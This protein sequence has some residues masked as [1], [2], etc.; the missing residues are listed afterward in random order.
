MNFET[1]EPKYSIKSKST[2]RLCI[3]LLTTLL[4][5]AC[6]GDPSKTYS[7]T[8][9]YVRIKLD[10]TEIE[11]STTFE[12][13]TV[14]VYRV[15]TGE[16]MEEELILLQ[17]SP[18]QNGKVELRGNLESP[19]WVEAQVS[20][21]ESSKPLVSRSY[22]EPGETVS[23]AVLDYT[24]HW[25][26]EFMHIGTLTNVQDPAK[27]F[28]LSGDL[29]PLNADL[30]NTLVS[31]NVTNWT[32]E[33]H[34]YV[35]VGSVMLQDGKFTLEIEVEEP[36]V[37]YLDAYDSDRHFSLWT[38]IV[39]ESGVTIL[40]HPR[41]SSSHATATLPTGW[42]QTGQDD[43]ERLRSYGLVA[44]AG[45]GKH[46]KLV[47]SWQQSYTFQLRLEE[48]DEAREEQSN[49]QDT[50]S[51]VIEETDETDAAEES[52][53]SQDDRGITTEPSEGC[54][55][56]DLSNVLPTYWEQPYSH[57]PLRMNEL[58]S[59]LRRIRS[60]VLDDIARHAVDPMDRL[61]ALEL[62]ALDVPEARVEKLQILENLAHSLPA[63][64]T[65][66]RVIPARD[67][68]TAV[69]E[70]VESQERMVPGQ[71]VPDFE[72][73]D[74]KGAPTNLYS[75]L[76]EYR[77]VLLDFSS[78]GPG[79]SP[80]TTDAYKELQNLFASMDF[81]I[82]QVLVGE[83]RVQREDLSE[84]ES[85]GWIRL[86]E[87]NAIAKSNLARSYAAVHKNASYFVDSGGC[88]IQR[89]LRRDSVKDF[90]S[91][92]FENPAPQH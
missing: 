67:F 31:V 90:L 89:D 10:N 18:F 65:S 2:F 72:L 13:G 40:A 3:L 79:L 75:I 4:V 12:S 37:A 6:S 16:S 51:A 57:M 45:R 81:Q 30:T 52:P 53:D 61:L 66:A 36:T 43:V 15:E 5:T 48:L 32:D 74:L 68:L 19:M 47:E 64:V 46:A 1:S 85:H 23:L 92:Y 69:V 86:R 78:P 60:N 91:S 28:V 9:E 82:V 38:E 35:N 49:R 20:S 41:G 29:S 58:W 83:D 21:T 62:E 59:E 26:D 7:F 11:E 84:V 88:I 14:L 24:G 44:V 34:G 22:V 17:S 25:Q 42:F 27:R 77:L 80:W 39:V 70:S 76:N 63:H 54:E 56:V 71:R 8:V 33:G 87:S 73:P 55:H 50:T